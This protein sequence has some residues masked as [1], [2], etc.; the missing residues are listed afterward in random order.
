MSGTMDFWR[1]LDMFSPGTF[2]KPVYVL[3]S[4]ATGSYII[5]TL[6]KIGVKDIHVFDFDKVK[7]HNLPNQYFGLDDCDVNK[8]KA[9]AEAM[10][11]VCGVEIKKHSSKATS[12]TP[13]QGIVFLEVDKMETRKEIWLGAI[14]YNMKVDLMIDTRMGIGGGRI[15]T[16][17]PFDKTDVDEYEKTLYADKEPPPCTS[18]SINTTVKVFSGIAVQKLIKFHQGIEYQKEILLSMHPTLFITARSW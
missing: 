15:Y 7:K 5:E 12:A 14:K 16:I 18:R 3:G 2:K 10:K 13:L 9:I 11:R 17:R 8:A 1:Q 6:C 4:G